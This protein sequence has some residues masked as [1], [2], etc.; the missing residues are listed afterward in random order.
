MVRNALFSWKWL[1]CK[2]FTFVTTP[3][4]NLFKFGSLPVLNFYNHSRNNVF[5]DKNKAWVTK[6]MLKP[7]DF[8]WKVSN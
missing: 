7:E 4:K 2:Y 3:L 5:G 8:V 1:N 6:I